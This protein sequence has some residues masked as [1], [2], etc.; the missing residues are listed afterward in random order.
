M[1]LKSASNIL[2]RYPENVRTVI[3]TA[4]YGVAAGLTAVAFLILT[5]RVFAIT[6]LSFA[7]L[8]IVQF[9]IWSLVTIVVSSLL[10]G[11]LLTRM[12]KDA[13]GSGIPQLKAAYWKE[14]GVV[15]WRSVWVKFLAGI[16]SIGGGASMGREGPTVY[17]AGGCASN[18]AGWLGIPRQGRRHATAVGAAAGLAAAFNT[19]LTAI[20]FVLE[21]LIGDMN[22]RFLGGVVLS[23][24]TG[25]FIVYWI[26]GKQP[27]F[28]LPL[29][30]WPSWFVYLLVPL[31]AILAGLIGMFYQRVTL[32]LREHVKYHSK[33]PGWIRPLIGG[34]ITWVIGCAVFAACGRP[35]VFGLGYDDLTDAL[36]GLMDWRIAGL[37]VAAKLI[38]TICCY[39]WEGCGGIFAPMLFLGGLTGVFCSGVVSLWLPIT[40][41][42]HVILAAVGMSA[43]FGALVRVPFTS[44]MMVFEMTHQFSMVPALMIGT[45]VSQSIARSGGKLNFYDALLVQDGHELIKI[46]PPRDIEGWHNLPVRTIANNRPVSICDL[47]ESSLSGFLKRY[48]YRCFPFVKDGAVSG[49]VTRD[50]IEK[51]LKEKRLP[52]V[53]PAV[54]CEAEE[55]LRQVEQK[56]IQ[57]P[58][59][60]L[61]VVNHDT[62]R[63]ESVLTLHDLLRA[64]ASLME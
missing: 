25:A 8:S 6:Y 44:L 1:N 13:A 18:I 12:S 41:A 2:N 63:I 54:T 4:I 33:I 14:M 23:S 50:E 47:S 49:T 43:C 24:V 48:P 40:P 64:R 22:S 20:T 21:E 34:L 28:I 52:V 57:A 61:V 9:M 26:I 5:R 38:A 11:F 30:D 42:D 58:G 15:S 16:L 35:G 53:E 27:A 62:A 55:T 59:E 36:H 29:V 56:F 45:I 7:K 31:V 17:V 51:A 3:L 37:F 39:G 10:V 60:M 19:P 32:R 46:K